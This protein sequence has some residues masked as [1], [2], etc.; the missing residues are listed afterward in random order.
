MYRWLNC[1]FCQ[2][3]RTTNSIEAA[4]IQQGFNFESWNISAK[5]WYHSEYSVARFVEQTECLESTIISPPDL[6]A[7]GN[8]GGVAAGT[9]VLPGPIKKGRGRNKTRKVRRGVSA[10]LRRAALR[11]EEPADPV[12]SG[13]GRGGE[14]A[15]LFFPLAMNVEQYTAT[16][17]DFHGGSAAMEL[18]RSRGTKC[19]LYAVS[20]ATREG[21]ATIPMW[22][23]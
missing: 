16:V 2:K 4:Q 3:L 14:E 12:P 13:P 19:S 9:L 8:S 7:A 17:A 22:R 1:R 6:P 23:T 5:Q 20:E 21:R 18:R 10:S 15:E 11:N